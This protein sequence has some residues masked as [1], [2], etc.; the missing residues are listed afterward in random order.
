MYNSVFFCYNIFS[1]GEIVMEKNNSNFEYMIIESSSEMFEELCKLCDN[2]VVIENHKKNGGTLNYTG[3]VSYS[4]YLI[5]C[6]K[7]N[8]IIGFNSLMNRDIDGSIYVV[9]IAV[10]NAYKKMRIGTE[11]INQ[12]KEIALQK[13]RKITADVRKYNKASQAL[14]ESCGFIKNN[15]LYSSECYSYVYYQKKYGEKGL[16]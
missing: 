15:N 7:D 13:Q 1:I 16:K 11:I 10:K 14:F 6:V 4:D 2:E 8:N 5:I 3:I 9:Q 12:A